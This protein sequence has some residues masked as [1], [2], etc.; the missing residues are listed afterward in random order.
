MKVSRKSTQSKT[1]AIPNIQFQDQQLTSFAGTTLLQQLFNRLKLK[2]KIGECF[3]HLAGNNPAYSHCMIVM[4]LIVH[5]FLGKRRLQDIQ[6]YC[7]DPMV[8]RLLGLN[9]MPNCSTI[10]RRMAQMDEKSVVGLRE[11]NRDLVLTRL[12]KQNLNRLTLD[13][14]GSVLST[15]RS[16]EG[17]AVGF[18]K[19]KKGQRS[20]YPLFCTIAQTG[21]VLDVWHRPGNV[22]DSNGA[23]SFILACIER[24][25][26][27]M[28]SI[29]IEVRMDSAFFSEHIVEALNERNIEFSIS[30]PFAR[31]TELKAMI[32]K[33]QRWRKFGESSGYFET[34]WKP[35]SWENRFRFIFIRERVKVQFK[36]PIQLDMFTPYDEDQEFKVIITNKKIQTKKLVHYHNGR[37]Y[38][39]NIFSELK[40]QV[41]MDYVPTRTL[42]G[43]KIWLMASLIV[44]NLNR[45]MQMV[46]FDKKRN[47]TE[48]RS[49]LWVFEKIGT[50]R[51]NLINIAGRLTQPKGKLTLTMNANKAVEQEYTHIMGMLVL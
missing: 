2:H 26:S 48:K 39:E 20:Y 23:E 5:L 32:E 37:G 36:G 17:T 31:Y 25:K 18:N 46:C 28:P 8:L 47:T 24:V 45:E 12:N 33:R 19:K 4:I 9:S 38:Q 50:I 7:D 3:V 30:V 6:Y 14:D 34:K 35:K 22:H 27:L 41:Q 15:G 51:N 29:V 43:N 1:H 16:A 42:A 49:P 40:S 21:Q 13:F 44:H 10:S 11:V